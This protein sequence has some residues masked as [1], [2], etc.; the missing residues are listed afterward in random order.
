VQ[1][2]A[3]TSTERPQATR[4]RK[5]DGLTLVKVEVLEEELDVL[6]PHGLLRTGERHD[7]DSI[8]GSL[9]GLFPAAFRALADGSLRVKAPTP[10]I[11]APSLAS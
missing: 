9:Y 2:R 1:R 10:K 4:R 11:L 5:Q 6:V 3:L 8:A 7:P